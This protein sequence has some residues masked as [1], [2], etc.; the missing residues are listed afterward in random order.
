VGGERE[1]FI[2]LELGRR[3]RFRRSAPP[4]PIS[5]AITLEILESNGWATVRLWDNADDVDEH[6]EH[7]YTQE[8]GKQPPTILD[9]KSSNDAMAA[10]IRKAKAVAPEIVRRWSEGQ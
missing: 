5:Y 7:A 4:P 8:A 6:H 10:A 3:I 2:D 1:V 9:F